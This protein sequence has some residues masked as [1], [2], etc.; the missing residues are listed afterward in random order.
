[1]NMYGKPASLL[2]IVALTLPLLSL[3]AASATSVTSYANPA[4]SETN[5]IQAIKPMWS[6]ETDFDGQPF[7]AVNSGNNAI[8]AHKGKLHAINAVTGKTQWSSSLLPSS[9]LIAGNGTLYFVDQKG[10]LV[11]LNAKTGKPFWKTNTGISVS[12]SSSTIK[13]VDG[14]LYAGGPFTLQAYNPVNGKN[15]WKQKTKSEYGGPY[16]QGVYDGV[17]VA[18]MTVNGAL[19]IDQY[20]GY[21]PKTGKRLWESGGNNGPVLAYRSG[22]LYARDQY[23]M[24]SPDHALLLNK[25]R[26]KTGKM[27]KANEYVQVED[28]MFQTADQ[29]FVEGDDLYIAMRKY[30]EGTL[31]G[32][33]SMLYRFK[34]DEDPDKQ[35]PM[36]Y[37]GRG[38]FLAGPYS[39]RFFVQKELRFEAVPLN[40]KMSENY[41]IPS[42][43]VSR[44]DLIAN[45]AYVGVSDGKFYIID[46]PS[47]RTLGVVKTDARTYGQTLVI[48]SAIIVQAEGKLIAVTKPTV[49]ARF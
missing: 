18:S 7:P 14:T 35:T 39:N 4:L 19:T 41:N 1:M 2:L 30:S 38:D 28:G 3:S 10:M 43:P 48:G 5:T 24:S 33:S 20:V 49:K 13:L 44:L 9:E 37:E 12:D 6:A 34:L 26:V 36:I 21:N 25:I 27:T 8:Y 29:V 22:Y 17:L 11:S 47:G 31:E 42:N 15:L 23:P 32:F 45:H 46:I 16:I 40:G